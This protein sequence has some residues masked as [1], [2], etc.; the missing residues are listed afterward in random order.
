[1]TQPLLNE[2]IAEIEQSPE[3][4]IPFSRYMELALYHP[5]WGYYQTDRIKLGKEGD[6]FT[7]A[8]V[9]SIVGQVLGRLFRRMVTLV[10]R[11]EDWV[12]VEMGAGD[13]RLMEQVA[14]EWIAQGGKPD[15]LNSY[16]VET[17]PYHRR[18]QQERLAPLPISFHWSRSLQEVPRAK[19]SFLYVNE[20]VDAFPV[21]RIKKEGGVIWEA[22]VIKG[23]HGRLRESWQPLKQA[24]DPAIWERAQLLA[25]GQMAEVAVAARQWIGEVAAWMERG[26]L[27]TIDYGGETGELLMRSHGTLRAYREHRLLTDLYQM[28]G[29]MDLTAH[30]DFT[31]LRHWGESLHMRTLA[32]LTQADFLLRAGVL[33]LL[34]SKP[35][36][37]PFS[38]EAKRRR[39][40][41]QLIHPQGMGES[42]R[43]LLQAKGMPAL[44]RQQLF[45]NL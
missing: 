10:G 12:L 32:Y 29:E 2:I 45:P 21:H 5:T 41:T 31:S 35:V 38:P 20:L 11:E 17:S 39:A 24:S 6:F 34:P 44:T 3:R 13:G 25:E 1:M 14:R 23:M 9:G 22:H 43:V 15:K 8:H 27:L 37:D 19:Y 28:P 42:F 4:A 18:L 7:N 33:D 30:V 26:I 16:L 36:P 40:I